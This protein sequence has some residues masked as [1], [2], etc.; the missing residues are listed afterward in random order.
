MTLL[1]ITLK[2]HVTWLTQN[3]SNLLSCYSIAVFI[4]FGAVL[5]S[6]WEDWNWMDASYFCFVT[7]STIGF[8]DMVPGTTNI[9]SA[10]S[11]VQL[12]VTGIYQV[13]PQGFVQLV[14]L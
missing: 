9:D 13:F 1:P 7:F 2:S 11:Q 14:A 4:I 3:A 5:F 10:S 12:I 6:V 8:G